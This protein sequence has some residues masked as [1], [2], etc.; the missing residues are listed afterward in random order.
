MGRK[1]YTA[2][3]IIKDNWEGERDPRIGLIIWD[4][5]S[6]WSLAENGPKTAAEI[7][8]EWLGYEVLPRV[9]VIDVTTELMRLMEKDP[10]WIFVSA[11]GATLIIIIKDSARLSLQ[12]EGITLASSMGT[13]DEAIVAIVGEDAEGWFTAKN[14]PIASEADIPGMS[15]ILAQ[16]ERYRGWAVDEVPTSYVSSCMESMITVEG[17]RLALEEVGYE[18]LNGRAVRDGLV[19]I[20]GFDIGIL[21]PITISDDRP[22]ISNWTFVYEIQ[23][24]RLLSASDAL[25]QY[26]L[27]EAE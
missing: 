11:A 16:A 17:I 19:S 8:V 10:D 3:W 4:S 1:T 6:S 21:P 14:T 25:E 5:S 22:Y 26:H 23:G 9:G 2:E 27:L 20:K 24:G 12:E 7:G 13:L 18:N 15:A